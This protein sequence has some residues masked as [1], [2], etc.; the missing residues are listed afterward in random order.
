MQHL[1]NNTLLQGGKYKIERVLG[2]G[3]FGVTYLAT[4]ELLDRKV[5]IKEFFFKDSCSRNAVGEVSLGT[6]GN[7]DLIERFL[8]KFI[9]EARTISQLD[10]SNIIRILDIFKE[11]G[12][13]YYVMEY[14]EGNSLEDIVKRRG[15][16]P[17]KEAV[18]YIR[19]IAKAL[20][21]VHQHNI[22]HL[23]V[24]PAN[25][26]V[27][28]S[29]NKAILID[30]GISKQYDEL[31]EQTSTTPVGI[32]YGY[33][34]LEQ[35]RPGG[36][37]EFSPQADI[38]SL[39]ATLFKLLTGE[40]P[41]QAMEILNDGLPNSIEQFSPQVKDAIKQAMQVRK[42][43]RP[44]SIGSFISLFVN[45]EVKNTENSTTIPPS[46]H[47]SES[48]ELAQAYY[49]KAESIAKDE[50][51]SKEDSFPFYLKAAQL[52][53]IKAQIRVGDAYSYGYGIDKDEKKGLEW[54]KKAAES[55][56]ADALE[57]MAGCYDG[58][59]GTKM[60]KIK[61]FELY[62]KAF[63]LYLRD[64]ENGDVDAMDMVAYHYKEGL[65][66][67]KNSSKVFDWT[68]KR[69][70]KTPNST[71]LA[72][73]AYYYEVGFGTE[74]DIKKSSEL[75]AKVIETSEAGE[76]YEIGINFAYS[77]D[78]K[79]K[80]QAHKW[81]MWATEKGDVEVI[82]N[83]ALDYKFGLGVEKN[84]QKSIYFYEKA[85]ILDDV[86]AIKSM[87]YIYASDEFKRD[88]PK[89]IEY[90][91]KAILL[92]DVDAIIGL[93]YLLASENNNSK[94]I[95]LFV[96]AASLGNVEAMVY[97]GERYYWGM[98]VKKNYAKAIEW[99][100]KALESE[101]SNELKKGQSKERI[102]KNIG[103][104]YGAGGYGIMKNDSESSKWEKLANSLSNKEDTKVL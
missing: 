1:P 104:M 20:D 6:I 81:F 83:I 82:N 36:V 90:F 51:S 63:M 32:S 72:E 10:H 39:G 24:K 80:E 57:K 9:K 11:N 84:I 103:L 17:E 2:Q 66:I 92:G 34:P 58:G 64:A 18:D 86:M 26:M 46:L 47:T 4:Q 40:I 91:E 28:Q 8:N 30:F 77:N 55:G 14:I 76:L 31:G 21:Y 54:F 41:P 48:V 7:R 75:L 52:G 33:A 19:Q 101:N 69:A 27:R 44:S 56:N 23:D 100:Q 12:T 93:A 95:E 89:A 13:A 74:R 96:K 65:G 102:F 88:I 50:E 71:S 98:G 16:L 78:K 43:D 53:H 25:I 38:Y 73:L 70:E 49:E 87:A 79:E 99:Y 94:A 22:N 35:Y 68:K 5:C 15:A 37:K 29:D 97:L 85:A 59:R 3:G 45:D 61:A 60:D 42:Q 67:P 62:N